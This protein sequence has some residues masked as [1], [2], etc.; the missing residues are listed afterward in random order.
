ML[1]FL[2]VWLPSHDLL[3]NSHIFWIQVP[4]QTG[5]SISLTQIFPRTCD[6]RNLNLSPFCNL[7][8]QSLAKWQPEINATYGN[9]TTDYTSKLEGPLRLMY[10]KELM[11]ERELLASLVTQVLIPNGSIMCF[12]P[13]FKYRREVP[14]TMP[15]KRILLWWTFSLEALLL[16]V[17]IHLL[18]KFRIYFTLFLRVW[19]ISKNDLA[20]LH[21]QLGRSLWSL[22]WHQLCVSYWD[23][24]LV[25]HTPFWELLQETH[26]RYTFVAAN[27]WYSI[28]D[29]TLLHRNKIKLAKKK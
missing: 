28:F 4:I 15:M 19:E 20:W 29:L 13:F 1:A 22:S 5:Q 2:Q 25:H 14:S 10:P 11:A 3:H 12:L 18:D 8:A 7:S 26:L 27:D 24:I 21:R 9:T 23:C 17:K 6:S 16:L